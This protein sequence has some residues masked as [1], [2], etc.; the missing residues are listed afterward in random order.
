M[1]FHT[2]ECA[3]GGLGEGREGKGGRE[4]EGERWEWGGEKGEG[5]W[6]KDWSI[7]IM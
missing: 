4:G 2:S 3:Q 5:V 7:I 1:A 6:G